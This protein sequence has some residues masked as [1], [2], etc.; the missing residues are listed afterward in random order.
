[1]SGAGKYWLAG[2]R[3]FL[4][5][6]P[7]PCKRYLRAEFRCKDRMEMGLCYVTDGREIPS[8]LRGGMEFG[9]GTT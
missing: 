3:L 7:S 6:G 8:R 9:L 2:W 5:L 4:G 1:M